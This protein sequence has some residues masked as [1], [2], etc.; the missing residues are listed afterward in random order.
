VKYPAKLPKV[1]V[2]SKQRP[3]DE[4]LKEDEQVKIGI[5]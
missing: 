4:K 2:L 5:D 1:M 3:E